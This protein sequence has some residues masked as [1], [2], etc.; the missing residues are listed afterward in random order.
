MAAQEPAE[1]MTQK[2]HRDI[3]FN[4]F[5]L[6]VFCLVPGPYLVLRLLSFN[7]EISSNVWSE[8]QVFFFFCCVVV[9]AV[10]VFQEYGIPY[11]NY[12]WF[13]DTK[14]WISVTTELWLLE[15]ILSFPSVS[16]ETFGQLVCSCE[17]LAEAFHVPSD[18]GHFVPHPGLRHQ[19][20]KYPE[21]HSGKTQVRE[22][23]IQSIVQFRIRSFVGR[24]R[25]TVVEGILWCKVYQL[26]SEDCYLWADSK[27]P[28]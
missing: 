18:P 10:V 14:D 4:L 25:S 20:D 7:S 24:T 6:Q 21:T 19:Q 8:V 28:T 27:Q 1:L 5:R 13:I 12:L 11:L 17:G 26:C 22:S 15:H 3:C 9:A 2:Q 23:M 16:C